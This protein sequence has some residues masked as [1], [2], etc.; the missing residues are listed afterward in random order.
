MGKGA[1]A[2]RRGDRNHTQ[3]DNNAR[4]AGRRKA[5][6]N[7][8]TTKKR[9]W[10]KGKKGG[11]EKQVRN[12]SAKAAA[13]GGLWGVKKGAKIKQKSVSLTSRGAGEGEEGGK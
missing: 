7:T 9:K 3:K 2:C 4:E 12:E 11:V 1:M 5:S 10:G 13:E 6:E 8:S